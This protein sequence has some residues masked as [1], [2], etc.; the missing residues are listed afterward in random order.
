MKFFEREPKLVCAG[1]PPP[2]LN[3]FRVGGAALLQA[4]NYFRKKTDTE[5]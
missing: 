5:K 3:P 1:S 4:V 2:P